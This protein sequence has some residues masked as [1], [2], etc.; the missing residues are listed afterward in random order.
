MP[1]SK[2]SAQRETN[3]T[4]PS[5]SAVRVTAPSRLHF[6]M[7]SFGQTH[8][9]RYG[10]CGAMLSAPGLELAITSAESCVRPESWPSARS[11]SRGDSHSSMDLA[12][13]ERTTGCAAILKCGRRRA[14]MSD[15]V[16]EHN[17]RWRWPP[18]SM[19]FCAGP[20]WLSPIWRVASV[21]AN[22]RAS[23]PMGLPKAECWSNRERSNRERYRL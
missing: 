15:S 3:A 5:P 19:R 23:A 13:T 6:G 22:G 7:L 18:A 10:G 12:T 14:S 20:N 4:G 1:I 9:R 11:R 16:R 8:V 2:P 17:W 21:V